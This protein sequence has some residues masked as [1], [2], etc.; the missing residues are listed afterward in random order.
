[1]SIEDDWPRGPY[2][3]V[4]VTR[5]R[6]RHQAALRRIYPYRLRTA[7]VQYSG[8]ELDALQDRIAADREALEAE[9]FDVRS[10][11]ID[12]EANGV[13]V[14]MVSTRADHQAYFH[15]R[16]GPAVTTFAT[17]EDTRPDC[18]KLDRVRVSSTGRSLRLDWFHGRSDDL[19][20]V[21]LTEHDNR[22]EVGIVL[23]VD[24]FFA[25]RRRAAGA[26]AR[27]AQQAARRPPRDRRRHRT[28]L[29]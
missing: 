25:P 2:L 5:D 22:V 19:E 1:M 4:R 8:V 23:R 12:I 15:A 6:E 7:T 9:G 18:A 16:Y 29:P 26:H 11:S 17:R 27:A 13:H 20:R 10:L 14:Q 28:R 3:L 21:E 24:A